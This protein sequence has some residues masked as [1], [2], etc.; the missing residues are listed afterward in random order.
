MITIYKITSPTGKVYVG[1][2]KDYRKR[3]NHYRILN[4][5][6]QYRLHNS[7]KKYG[8]NNHT[9]EVL[10]EVEL[11]VAD[12][13][14]QHWIAHYKC[15][16]GDENKGLNLNRGGNRPSHTPETKKKLSEMFSGGKH[17]K[18]K[19]L[20]QYTLDGILLKEWECM[21]CIQRELGYVTTW[22]SKATKNNKIAY[23]YRWSY[24]PMHNS[25]QGEQL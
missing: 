18:A 10:E 19:K 3:L 5:R 25:P 15:Y 8:F 21:K 9:F 12:S 14:E 7:L 17:G 4:C 1:Q 24:S 13:R 6:T 11:M 16:W 2:T 22:L 20:Y 23:G